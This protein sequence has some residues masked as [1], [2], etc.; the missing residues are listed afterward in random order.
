MC[1]VGVRVVHDQLQVDEWRLI[2]GAGLQVDKRET[3]Q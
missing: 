1:G 3:K 2:V